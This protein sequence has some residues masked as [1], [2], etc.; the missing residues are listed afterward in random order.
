MLKILFVTGEEYAATNVEKHIGIKEAT[1]RTEDNGGEL[2][3]KGEFN[4]KL[5]V[6]E[7][8]TVDPYFIS[9]IRDRIQDSNTQHTNFFVIEGGG[10]INYKGE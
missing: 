1:K 6:R 7:F 8:D 4:A 10:F 5:A 2:I 3:L 9:F